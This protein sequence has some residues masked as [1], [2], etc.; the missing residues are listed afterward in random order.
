MVIKKARSAVETPDVSQ[1][2]LRF[3]NRGT[4]RI[5]FLNEISRIL[6]EFSESDAIELRLR[7][8]DFG[9]HWRFTLRPDASTEF[10]V[11]Q[12][13]P[14]PG[15]W[16][17]T[18][19]HSAASFSFTADEHTEGC[20]ELRSTH[21]NHFTR[22]RRAD[23]ERIAPMVG[24]AV[25]TRRAQAALRDR[26]RGLTCLYEIGRVTQHSDASLD[27]T[28]QAIVSLLPSASQFPEIAA[29]AIILDGRSWVCRGFAPGPHRLSAEVRTG[30]HARGSVEVVYTA[31]RPEFAAGAFL[32]EERSLIRTIA[33]EIG[34][35]VERCDNEEQN[36]RLEAQLRHAD[37]LAT[38]GQLA[39]G[40]AHELNDP[41]S[42]I[43]GFAQLI[44]NQRDLAPGVAED[45]ARIVS[46]SLD[47]REIIRNLLVFARQ[48]SPS[49]ADVNLNRIVRDGLFLL[50][51][52]CAEADIAVAVSAAPD[53]PAIPADAGQLHQVLVNLVVNSIQ[54]MPE[55]GRLTIE[56]HAACNGV[57][58]AVEDTGIGMTP[59][60][61]AR[62]FTPFF[63]TKDPDQGTGLGLAVVDGIVAGHGGSIRVESAPGKG[64]RF[65]VT[66]PFAAQT[67][68]MDFDA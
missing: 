8:P 60:V 13:G 25:A 21:P 57:T 56:T 11:V 6:L 30:E 41:L 42:R 5:E 26:V 29:A 24:L 36:R 68:G 40:V 7:D 37:R 3:A 28:L 10:A 19:Y 17:E 53:L 23:L 52:R 65:E 1:R 58:L 9:Y 35:I 39:A 51:T 50:A 15:P 61:K 14:L 31:E 48:K 12:S 4:T 63:T 27:E 33:R 46:A 20:L 64:T 38:I 16:H 67:R 45:A 62:I 54:A 43:L 66:L 2:I 34:I 18:A 44:E 55:G 49:K 59:E 47:A 22:K 32:E